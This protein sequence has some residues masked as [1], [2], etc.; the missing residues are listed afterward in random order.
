MPSLT[1]LIGALPSTG[2]FSTNTAPGQH[3]LIE[4]NPALTSMSAFYGSDYFLSRAGIDLDK[5]NMQL[6]GDAY[7]ETKLVR[8]Q[9]FALTGKRLLSSTA[10][11]DAE[12]MQALMDSALRA[13]QSLDLT[14]GVALTQD[15]IANL[16]EDIVWLEKTVVDG[17][18]VLVPKVYLASKSVE[19]IAKGGSVIV[20][21]DVAVTTTG[22]IKNSGVLLAENTLTITADNVLNTGGTLKG[23][24]VAVAATDSIADTSGTISGGD[25][26][27]SAGKDIIVDTAKTTF[28]SSNTTSEAVGRRGE[29][30]ASGSLN[31]FVVSFAGV[32]NL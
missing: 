8:E 1:D 4:T 22:D 6:L 3:Y 19:N 31:M 17:H 5:S 32:T 9:I 28:A 26:T 16:T 11:S 18:E 30:A 23:Q 29:V 12:Q 15:Q 14:V 21:K 27:L 7:Y 24:T 25:V 13:K 2:L 20:G 10:T